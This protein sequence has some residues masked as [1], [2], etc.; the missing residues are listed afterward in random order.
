MPNFIGWFLFFLAFDEFGD[1]VRGKEYLK[2]CALGLTLLSGAAWG[3]SIFKPELNVEKFT[4]FISLLGVVFMYFMIGVLIK[5]AEDHGSKHVSTLKMLRI[6][7]LAIEIILSVIALIIT[8][9]NLTSLA[10][11]VLV[12]G[13]AGLGAAIITCITLFKLRKEITQA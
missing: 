13:F 6:V 3:M 10:V 4:S 1:Y 7:N 9:D 2:W 11:L 12:L 5:I 8:K